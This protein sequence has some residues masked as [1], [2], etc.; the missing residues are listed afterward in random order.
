MYINTIE[1]DNKPYVELDEVLNTLNLIRSVGFLNF[2]EE[3]NAKDMVSMINFILDDIIDSGYFQ[4][5]E[6]TNKMTIKHSSDYIRYKVYCR[7]Q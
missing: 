6:E 3:N 7:N 5:K 2:D 1:I 4:T